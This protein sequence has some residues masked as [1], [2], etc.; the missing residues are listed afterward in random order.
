MLQSTLFVCYYQRI[1]TSPITEGKQL[2]W[3]KGTMQP[4]LNNRYRFLQQLGRGGFGITYLAEDTH[5]PSKLRCVVKQFDPATADPALFQSIRQRF[6]REAAILEMLSKHSDKIPEL[7][8]YF[9]EG[10]DLYLVQEWIAGKDLQQ[11]V[12]EAGPWREADVKKLLFELLPVLTYV[13]KKGIIHRDIKP[14]NIILRADDHK[15]VLIDFGAVKE[16]IAQHGASHA[17]SSTIII[18][19]PGYMPPEQLAGEPVFASDLYALA[20]TAIFL[21]TGQDSPDVVNAV[22]GRRAAR[23]PLPAISPQLR[24]VLTK[25]TEPSTRA[26]FETADQMLAALNPA[27]TVVVPPRGAQRRNPAPAPPVPRPVPPPP[28]PPPLPREAPPIQPRRRSGL[29]TALYGLALLLVVAAVGVGAMT[30]RDDLAFGQASPGTPPET[31]QQTD[32]WAVFAAD[33][34]LQIEGTGDQRS[35]TTQPNGAGTATGIPLVNDVLYVDMDG[36]Q[37]EEAV[38]PLSSGGTAGN[39]GFL[40]YRHGQPTFVAQQRGY[41]Q[42]L[43]AAEGRL[44]ATDA[45]A[46]GWEPDCCPSGTR[47]RTYQLQGDQ[48]QVVNEQSAGN[49]EMQDDTVQHFYDLLNKRD[50]EAAYPF[51]GEDFQRKRPFDGWA[52]AY[53]M[54]VRTDAEVTLDPSAADT[55]RVA[56]TATDRT[57]GGGQKVQKFAGTWKLEWMADRGHWVLDEPNIKLVP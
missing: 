36:D 42:R 6:D 41:Q 29:R 43:S 2:R 40:V 39:A 1:A 24:A 49:A 8:A 53:T 20:I 21:L 37:T 54:T 25:A 57:A 7:Y 23:Q 32:W 26:R 16:V 11:L 17:T 13:H 46:S 19:S 50:F 22:T 12:H 5:R 44:V 28:P 31:I 48:L 9:P 55:V 27:P 34:Q 18:G 52:D 14:A 38:I 51:L 35:V 30:L 47:V 56:L 10:N 4:L 3:K 33:P 45:L 15:P